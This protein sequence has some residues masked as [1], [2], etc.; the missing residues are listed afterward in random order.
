MALPEIGLAPTSPVIAEVGTFVIA[1]LEST[2]KLPADQRLTF[3]GPAG[4]AEVVPTKLNVKLQ[5]ITQIRAIEILSKVFICLYISDNV[6][7]I[8]VK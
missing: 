3:A 6:A 7:W 2:A 8:S 1:V 5:A 4:S